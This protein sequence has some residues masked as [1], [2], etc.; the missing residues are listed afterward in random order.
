[1]ILRW[2]YAF[3]MHAGGWLFERTHHALVEDDEDGG[4]MEETG[5]GV[6]PDII[7]DISE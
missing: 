4:E 7:E 1:M 6:T 5:D 3:S 2:W